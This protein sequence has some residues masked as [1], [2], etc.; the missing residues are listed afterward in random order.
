MKNIT[1]ITFSHNRIVG[2]FMH[3]LSGTQ[4]T[5]TFLG[6]FTVNVWRCVISVIPPA[7]ADLVSLE[8]L[9]LFNNHVEEL[10][11]ALSSLPKLKILNL[12]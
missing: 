11:T 1:R 6:S 10:P 3:H 2:E 5:L 12:G 8:H 7:I 9:N 4:I